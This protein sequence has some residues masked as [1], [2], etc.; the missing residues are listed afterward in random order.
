[1]VGKRLK[2]DVRSPVEHGSDRPLMGDQ[3]HPGRGV[4][5]HAQIAGQFDQQDPFEQ[6]VL[7][8]QDRSLPLTQT[9]A[10][11]D[12]DDDSLP[13]LIVI[14]RQRDSISVLL[15]QGGG[16]FGGENDFA[17]GFLP[18]AVAVADLS[19]PADS[20]DAGDA[21]GNPDIIVA[22]ESGRVTL[23]LGDGNGDFQ[24]SDQDLR[25]GIVLRGGAVADFDDNDR[26][27]WRCLIRPI[28]S[29]SSATARGR[30]R[31]AR[32][33]RS[34]PA[35]IRLISMLVILMMIIISMSSR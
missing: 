7:E 20:E 4:V 9:F 13:D 23:L 11:A 30:F 33:R 1:M 17:L 8:S 5:T 19:S 3:G 28:P 18:S 24:P 32:R 21:D 10:L 25:P 15:N 22:D 29:I 27:T 6:L 16:A 14:N 2:K 31:H 35:K 26:L 34:T 12:V